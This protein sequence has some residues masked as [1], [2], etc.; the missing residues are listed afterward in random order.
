MLY[1][2]V[3]TGAAVRTVRR[4]T[5]A[6]DDTRASRPRELPLSQSTRKRACP[7]PM[8][9]L[10]LRLGCDWPEAPIRDS[11]ATRSQAFRRK[12]CKRCR[13][14]RSKSRSKRNGICRHIPDWRSGVNQWRRRELNPRPQSRERWLLRVCP[15]IWVSPFAS[16]AGG[17]A[18]RQP[19][20][21]SPRAAQA[22]VPGAWPAVCHGLVPA[23][24]PGTM[25]CGLVS[26]KRRVGSRETSHLCC[27]RGFTRPPAPRLATTPTNRP[28]RSLSS[29]GI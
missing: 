26:A 21:A 4:Q 3:G 20:R 24:A 28:H 22:G 15:A 10:V 29:P 12:P 8:L 11:P 18:K 19:D 9:R 23:Q 2:R 6:R 14:C 17:V 25:D 27:C 1:S 16:H 7:H 13:P 5:L